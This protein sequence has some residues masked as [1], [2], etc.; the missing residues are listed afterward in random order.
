MIFSESIYYNMHTK[1]FDFF[2]AYECASLDVQGYDSII[3]SSKDFE[4]SDT[5]Q[6]WPSLK[7][8]TFLVISLCNEAG[9]ASPH[10]YITLSPEV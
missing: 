5:L 2:E 8:Q 4:I 10:W 1:F 6:A 7:S 3:A 9:H